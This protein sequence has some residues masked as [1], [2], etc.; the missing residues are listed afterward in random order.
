MK[1][2]Q[3]K[4][5]AALALAAVTAM[6]MA[7]CGK[8]AKASKTAKNYEVKSGPYYDKGYDLKDHE[9]ITMYV[10]GDRPKDMDE[11]VKKAND[12]YFGPNLNVDL[13]VEFLN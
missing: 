5:I 4:R 12:E 2:N 8:Q 10:L 9:T 13:D 11:V 7:G 3:W 1:K 6:S